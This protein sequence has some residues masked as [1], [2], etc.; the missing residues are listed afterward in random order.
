MMPG[1]PLKGNER[2]QNTLF[3]QEFTLFLL[4]YKIFSSYGLETIEDHLVLFAEYHISTLLLFLT[5]LKYID[6]TD[7]SFMTGL[8][9]ASIHCVCMSI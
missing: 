9:F 6:F 8:H 4:I 2:N 1:L 5:L 3:C 7:H